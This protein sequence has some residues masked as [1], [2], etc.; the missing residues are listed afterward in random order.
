MNN[1]DV[2]EKGICLRHCDYMIER[3]KMLK[4]LLR[5]YDD[6]TVQGNVYRAS[7]TV[8]SIN[9][10]LGELKLHLGRICSR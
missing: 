6:T 3:L 8:D 5:D 7:R 2:S 1:Y 4:A 9:E 10:S